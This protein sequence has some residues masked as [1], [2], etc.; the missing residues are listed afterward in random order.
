MES[1]RLSDGA[2]SFLNATSIADPMARQRQRVSSGVQKTVLRSGQRSRTRSLVLLD[3]RFRHPAELA[4]CFASE[5]ARQGG[6]TRR[7]IR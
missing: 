2:Q 1:G 7:R 5:E 4:G 6:P 3:E